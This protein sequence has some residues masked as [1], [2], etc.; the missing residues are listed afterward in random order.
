MNAKTVTSHDVARLAGV[1]RSTV[2]HVLNGSNS[3]RLSEETRRKVQ[4]AA[5]TLGYKPNSAALMLRHGTTRTVGLLI[6]QGH[7]L[8]VDHYI[9]LLFAGIGR[10]LRREGYHL[11][12][13]T[14][15]AVPQAGATVQAEAAAQEKTAKPARVA[16]PREAATPARGTAQGDAAT[17]A[18]AQPGPGQ[19]AAPATGAA[20]QANRYTD[21]VQTRRIDGLIVLS[22]DPQSEELRAL[23]DDGFPVVLIGS[24]GS[25]REVS[26]TGQV[27]QAME[28]AVMHLLKLGHRHIGCVPFSAP[29]FPASDLR[30]AVLQRLLHQHGLALADNAIE[31]ADFSV[32]SGH[33]AAR[34]L[35]ARRP[36]LTAILAGNDTIALG[37]I[38]GAA[39]IGLRVPD[40]LSVV[41]FDDLP[42]AAWTEPALTTV[43][44]NVLE[45]GETAAQLLVERLT[46]A[47]KAPRQKQE[48]A[49]FVAR[50]STGPARP[51]P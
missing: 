13:E 28:D 45:Q 48:T 10:V 20:P 1:A 46:G 47:L 29:G 32:E 11:L 37:V 34:T 26:V 9:Q 5:A 3:V 51:A 31:H 14:F 24:I 16:T 42:F 21:L 33:R 22:P 39:S 43:Y 17:H 41:G 12:L 6:T 4:E 44:Q 36:D 8:M 25:D 30:T 19:R 7:A 38:G 40:A 49:R 2:S 23:V 18:P 27:T 50:T 15:D 35:L